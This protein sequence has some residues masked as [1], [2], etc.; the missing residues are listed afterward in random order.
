LIFVAAGEPF[1]D[2]RIERE[3]WPTIKPYA[4]FGQVPF[5]EVKDGDNHFSLSQSVAI[6]IFLI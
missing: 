3:N 2:N 5:L 4:P 1:E 6:G